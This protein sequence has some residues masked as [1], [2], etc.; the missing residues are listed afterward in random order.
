MSTTSLRD[1]ISSFLEE[2]GMSPTYFGKCA[3]GN[4]EL[5]SRLE[6][7]RSIELSTAERIKKFIET[8]RATKG[9]AA[10]R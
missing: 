4:S 6:R 1:E 9:G 2:T 3:V 8:Y 7:G 10:G 5:V